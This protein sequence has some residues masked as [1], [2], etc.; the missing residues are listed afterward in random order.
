MKIE[1]MMCNIQGCDGKK[2]TKVDES[3]LILMNLLM[4]DQVLQQVLIKGQKESLKAATWEAV[5]TI[6]DQFLDFNLEDKVVSTTMRNDRI[7]SL[8][9]CVKGTLSL[10][11]IHVVLVS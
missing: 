4:G 8:T 7:W 5:A 11:C 10:G 9:S 6:K 1:T 2:A 3:S